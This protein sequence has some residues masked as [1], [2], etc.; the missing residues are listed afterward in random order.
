MLSL[1]PRRTE[2]TTDPAARPHIGQAA[3]DALPYD[4]NLIASLKSDH[5]SLRETLD[6]I[7]NYVLNRQCAKIP[8]MLARFRDALQNHLDEEREQFYRYVALCVQD[9]AAKSAFIE[10]TNARME[11]IAR[12]VMIFT[13]HYTG[14]GVSRVNKDA[15]RH[16]LEVIS[17]LLDERIELEETSL[18]ALYQPSD[19]V[20]RTQADESPPDL[21]YATR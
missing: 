17:D 5:V 7:E 18:Y 20:M 12:Q 14:I 13:R 21:R 6:E 11:G 1:A 15:F 9:D 10:R 16:D 19:R 2:T 4:P 3:V 8:E